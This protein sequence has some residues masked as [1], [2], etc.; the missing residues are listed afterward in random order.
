MILIV[1]VPLFLH[2]QRRGY[3]PAHATTG[4]IWT[5]DFDRIAAIVRQ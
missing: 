2:L 1:S 4:G 5:S 3:L